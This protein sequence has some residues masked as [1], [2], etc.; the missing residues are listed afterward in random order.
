M[1]KKLTP[2]QRVKELEREVEGLKARI[3]LQ[4][5]IK[6]GMK[7]IDFGV[8]NTVT[9]LA[10]DRDGQEVSRVTGT[11]LETEY[12]ALTINALHDQAME[13]QWMD[14]SSIETKIIQDTSY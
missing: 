8:T 4:N 12:I 2:T 5:S 6:K 7:V 14:I 10:R 1:E 13:G 3:E 11:D 9:V